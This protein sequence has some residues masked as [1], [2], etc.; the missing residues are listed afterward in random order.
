MDDRPVGTGLCAQAAFPALLRVDAHAAFS[1]ADGT[2]AAGIDA[3]LAQT[4]AAAVRNGIGGGGAVV[5]GR[6]N[7][8]HH[9]GRIIRNV[10]IPAGS[11]PDP[12]ADDLPLL[13]DAAAVFRLRAGADAEDDHLPR[14]RRQISRPGKAAHLGR[15]VVFQIPDLFIVGQHSESSVCNVFSDAKQIKRGNGVHGG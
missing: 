2:E 6:T 8:L 13:I 9:V 11:Q 4:E 12:L 1:L 15:N 3:G 7:D 14:L 10:C 5:A